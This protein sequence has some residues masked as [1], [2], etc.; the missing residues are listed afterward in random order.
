M[1]EVWQPRW[2]DRVVLIAKY[3]ACAGKNEIVFTKAKSLKGKKFYV[4]GMDMAKCPLETNGTILCYAVPMFMLKDVDG[5]P[6][7]MGG[8]APGGG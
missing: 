5:I 7:G 1:I 4:D 6:L 8:E 3:K 2:H